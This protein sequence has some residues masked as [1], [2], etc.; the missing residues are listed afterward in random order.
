M[1]MYLIHDSVATTFYLK[2]AHRSVKF[3][4]FRESLDLVSFMRFQT[5][6]NVLMQ[7]LLFSVCNQFG[8]PSD[9]CK[10]L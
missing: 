7:T 8:K 6:L 3:T 10:E 5:S 1:S 9:L 4:I 2:S